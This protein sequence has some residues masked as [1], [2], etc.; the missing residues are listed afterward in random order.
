MAIFHAIFSNITRKANI[1]E[2]MFKMMGNHSNR[3]EQQ[4]SLIGGTE[5]RRENKKTSYLSYAASL[6]FLPVGFFTNQME[7]ITDLYRMISGR[8][9]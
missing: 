5:E 3:L 7:G 6:S 9:K 4:V 8:K 2:Q 1:V